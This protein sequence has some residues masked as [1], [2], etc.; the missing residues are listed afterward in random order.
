MGRVPTAVIAALVCAMVPFSSAD[1][2]TVRASSCSGDDVQAAIEF[3]DDGD[4]VVI[5]AGEAAWTSPVRIVKKAI[6][7]RGA[8]MDRTVIVDQVPASVVRNSP[9]RIESEEGKPF[10]ITGLTFRGGET[11]IKWDGVI[12]L[13]GTC[14]NWRI[15]HVRFDRPRTSGIRTYGHTYG[16][17]DHCEFHLDGTQGM[18]VWHDGWNGASYGDGSWA[19][20]LYLGTEKAVYIEDNTFECARPVEAVDSMGGG[21]FVFRH[22]TVLNAG[23]GNHGTESSGRIR[24][25]RSYEIYANT[26]RY[27]LKQPVTRWWTA[28]FL[29]GGTGVVYDNVFDGY[30]NGVIVKNFRDFHAFKFWGAADGTSPYDANDGITYDSG[31]HTGENGQRVLKCAGKN[32]KPDQWVGY[33]LRNVTKDKGS[34]IVSNTED[35]IVT[36]ADQ[37]APP[38]SWDEGDRFVILKA[39]PCIDQVGRSTGL[40]LSGWDPPMPQKWPEQ[41]LEPL[42]EWDNILN[43]GKDADI[44]S[45]SPHVVEDRDFYNDTRRPGYKPYVYPHPLTVQFPPG[46][47]EEAEQAGDPD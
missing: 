42:Y 5:P 17:V 36:L 16:V 15:D 11:K 22:N 2:A 37:Y 21:R 14:K 24:S 45:G 41:A 23:I 33:S 38:L 9:L 47:A 30:D 3:A 19:D 1:G 13:G 20:E 35:S 27:R 29:R 46:P 43:D 8:G 25:C 7:L 26:F 34:T 12:A 39:Y 44:A 32:W 31:E 40:L 6:T 28:V 18:V 10:R 4:V